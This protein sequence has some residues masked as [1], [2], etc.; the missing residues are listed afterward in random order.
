MLAE[1]RP[2]VRC[3]IQ[4]LVNLARK[5]VSET[6]ISESKTIIEAGIDWDFLLAAAVFHGV[7]PTFFKH[8][9]QNFSEFI[10]TKCFRMMT[11]HNEK[12]RMSNLA[13]VG[14]FMQYHRL[15]EK[16]NIKSITF[17]G[18]SVAI[19]LYD[20]LLMREFSDV[21]VLVSPSDAKAAQ[22]LLFETGYKP[23]PDREPEL[24]RDFYS[25]ELFLEFECENS[26][27]KQNPIGLID[28]HWH[29]QPQHVLPISFEEIWQH[30]TDLEME[31]RTVRTLDL[32]LH[33]ILLAVHASRH[34]W[35]R[36]LWICDIAE[37]LDSK[38]NT[39]IDW[40]IV[41]VLAAKLNVT[42]MVV[43]ALNLAREVFGCK[44]PYFAENEFSQKLQNLQT[45][46]LT[47]M[48]VLT[49]EGVGMRFAEWKFCTQLISSVP[50]KFKYVTTE[51]FHPGVADYVRLKLP[52]ALYKSYYFLHPAW[53]AKDAL[54][55]RLRKN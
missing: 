30:S 44:I 36:L 21:D 42:P 4:L 26:F 6:Q 8:L 43:L 49:Q 48:D 47:S 27:A 14:T 53:L 22:N 41:K 19:A 29:I 10:P 17:K 11:G 28:L 2:G 34:F 12:V 9:K 13:L 15:L 35:K 51:M 54:N 1:K 38:G 32:N 31:R 40:D 50:G 20:D 55:R 37:I 23:V 16:N 52:M 39:E 3:E 24:G 5:K 7:F 25:S 46:V 18:P 45:E 33:L